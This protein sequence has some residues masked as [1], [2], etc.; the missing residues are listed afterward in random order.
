MYIIAFNLSLCPEEFWFSFL[1]DNVLM[2]IS[3]IQ[4]RAS[5]SITAISITEP[6]TKATDM[7][8]NSR[9][10]YSID[11]LLSFDHEHI[12]DKTNPTV[13]NGRNTGNNGFNDPKYHI[14]L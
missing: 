7:Y 5:I 3:N 1:P 2:K 8:I 6:N 4:L 12:V 13:T 10:D 11:D 14:I 9:T